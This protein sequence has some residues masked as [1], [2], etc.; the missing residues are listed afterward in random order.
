MAYWECIALFINFGIFL[1]LICNLIYL[2]PE[3]ILYDIRSFGFI[4]A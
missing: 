4:K 1:L 2:E 3:Y